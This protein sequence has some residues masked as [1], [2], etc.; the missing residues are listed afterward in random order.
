MGEAEVIDPI[1]RMRIAS[2]GAAAD[3]AGRLAE[4][5]EEITTLLRDL[6]RCS[7]FSLAAWDPASNSH[8]HRTLASDGYSKSTLAHIDDG[9]VKSNRAFAIAHLQEPNGVRWRDLLTEWEFEFPETVTAQEYLI[10][11]GYKE[12]MTMCLWLPDGRYTGAIHMSWLSSASATDD[13]REIVQRFS[14]ILAALCDQLRAP[15]L[16]VEATAPDAFALI[17]SSAGL[18]FTLPN[19]EPGPHLGESGALRQLIMRRIGSGLPQRFLWADK[20]GGCHRVT[21]TPCHGNVCLVTDE[22][23]AWPFGLSPR[24]LQVL[25]LIASGASNPDI[26]QRLFISPRTVST[27]VE[28]ILDKMGCY[29][30]AKLA[31]MAVAEGLTL[32][33]EFSSRG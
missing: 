15:R 7:A 2:T 28:H 13:R 8:R 22:A 24:E 14:P 23:T 25:N 16:L 20:T 9:Y 32:A 17:V 33:E 18:V 21:I 29:S 5:A 3:P 4:S 30:R 12:G 1:V 26:S 31:A 6:V 19:R 27:H 11:A 10:P